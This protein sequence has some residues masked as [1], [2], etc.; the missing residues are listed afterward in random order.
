MKFLTQVRS[1]EER[2]CRFK[3]HHSGVYLPEIIKIG[4]CFTSL[5]VFLCILSF[6]IC[7]Y[8]LSDLYLGLEFCGH[9]HRIRS[10]QHRRN[11]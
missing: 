1:G 6:K 9:W 4:Q 11:V 2:K 5:R 10:G 3:Q 8:I 7:H